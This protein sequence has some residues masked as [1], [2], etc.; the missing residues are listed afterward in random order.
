MQLESHFQDGIL[1][2]CFIPDADI[3]IMPGVEWG[4]VSRLFTPAFW[5]FAFITGDTAHDSRHYRLGSNLREEVVAC[6]L[7][8]HG[9][10]GEVGVAAFRH[11]K[12]NGVFDRE[13]SAREIEG[14]LLQPIPLVDRSVRYRFPRQRAMRVYDAMQF[15]DREGP[16]N[17]GNRAFRDWLTGIDGVGKKTASWIT[18]N[19]RDAA[20]VAIIDIHVHRAGV[21]AGFLGPNENVSR[22]Y[23]DMESR[24]LMFADAI[25]VP[26]NILDCRIWGQLRSV[27]AVVRELLQ[28]KGVTAADRCGLPRSNNRSSPWNYSLFGNA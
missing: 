2:D 14:L 12:A 19:C 1:F 24:F 21:I 23:D 28:G 9:I 27:P 22:D 18:R 3:Q 13:L 16:P 26:A 10:I 8:G 6:L 11:L 5:R 25:D 17:C 7:G 15:I 20:D 4:D